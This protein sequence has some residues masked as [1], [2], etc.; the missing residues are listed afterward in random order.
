MIE[1][2]CVAN[3]VVGLNIELV[4]QRKVIQF[5]GNSRYIQEWNIAGEC[6]IDIGIMAEIPFGAGTE[7]FCARYLCVILEN[8]AD[9]FSLLCTKSKIGVHDWS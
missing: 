8:A 9:Q 1:K 2:R 4:G 5:T 6:K 7:N 3:G